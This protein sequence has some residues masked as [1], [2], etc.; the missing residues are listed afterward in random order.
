LPPRPVLCALLA[1]ATLPPLLSQASGSVVGSFTMFN[2]V[3]RYH[4][5]LRVQEDDGTERRISVHSLA[6]HLSRA[7]RPILLPAEG[8]AIGADQVDVVAHG[9]FDLTRL[10]C[11]LH[12]RAE[13]AR[14]TLTQDPFDTQKT[15]ERAAE[16]G[17]RS[18]R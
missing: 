16:L 5:E 18:E 6:P 1:L 10:L 15:L 9:L 4:L 11:D 7:A 17:C 12:P 14:A 13:R 3:V 8:H 2:R